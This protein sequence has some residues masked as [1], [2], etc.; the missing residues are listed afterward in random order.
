MTNAETGP[1]WRYRGKSGFVVREIAGEFLLIPVAMQDDQQTRI[2]VLNEQGKFLWERLQRPCTIAGLTEAVTESY[3]V[4][5][6][7]AERDIYEFIDQ[8][9]EYHFISKTEVEK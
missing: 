4:S 3:D 8:L 2:A 6:E 9:S 5:A 1:G 7:E